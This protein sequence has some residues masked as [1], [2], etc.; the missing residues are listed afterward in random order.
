MCQRQACINV[1]LQK[2]AYYLGCHEFYSACYYFLQSRNSSSSSKSAHSIY[3]MHKGTG[4][5]QRKRKP[6]NQ[7]PTEPSKK[8][9]IARNPSEAQS[10]QGLRDGMVPSKN[11]H[12]ATLLYN[13]SSILGLLLPC[14]QYFDNQHAV[15][16]SLSDSSLRLQWRRARK[17][18]QPYKQKIGKPVVSWIQR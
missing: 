4:P 2:E 9:R 16:D 18:Q 13:E 12:L 5:V 6:L 10:G 15:Q 11:T 1:K 8:R 17:Q 14:H 7:S 3:S